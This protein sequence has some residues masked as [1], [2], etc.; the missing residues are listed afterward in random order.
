[1]KTQHIL[2]K[3]TSNRIYTELY[4]VLDSSDVV[5]H[6]L[7]A[8]DPLGTFCQN[9]KNYVDEKQH[10]HLVFILNKT[11]L[12]PTYMTRQWIQYFSRIGPTIA[13][14]AHI[15]KSFGK[16]ALIQLLRQ[17][18]QIYMKMNRMQLSVGIV[19]FPNTGKSSIINTLRGKKVCTVAPIPGETKVWQYITL[20]KKIYL[21]DCPGVVYNNQT[22]D[23]IV[24]RGVCRAEQLDDPMIYITKIIERV[25]K[26]YL[27]KTYGISDFK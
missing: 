5:L 21:I 19:G 1:M 6:V 24:L 27:C 22:D 26:E 17:Y 16:G 7:D 20:M 18:V 12:I 23:Q 11:D 25:K 2:R 14:H 9:I 8:R 13:F 10:K 4:K 3:G 15:N